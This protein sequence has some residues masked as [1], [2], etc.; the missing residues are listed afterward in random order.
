MVTQIQVLA[1]QGVLAEF[2]ED[3]PD[4]YA[5]AKSRKNYSGMSPITKASGPETGRIGSLR[6]QPTPK[7]TPCF[8]RPTAPCGH[9]LARAY[10]DQ[11]RDRGATHYQSPRALANH[12]AEEVTHAAA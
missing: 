11:H 10:Y 12:T 9:H 1:G 2:G 6:P 4:R 3:P 7:G 8:C 5:D